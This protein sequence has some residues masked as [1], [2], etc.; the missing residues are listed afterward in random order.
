[1][2]DATASVAQCIASNASS[3]NKIGGE[4]RHGFTLILK[5]LNLYMKNY[6]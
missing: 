3:I 6:I 2:L 1:L 4:P 5:I